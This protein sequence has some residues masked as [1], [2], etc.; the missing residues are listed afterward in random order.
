MEPGVS[1]PAPLSMSP[2]ERFS[3]LGLGL[4]VIL[5]ASIVGQLLAMGG[6]MV[7]VPAKAMDL[8]TSETAL[9]L[10]SFLPMYCLA[11]PAGYLVLR[12]VPRDRAPRG[13]LER[14]A[15]GKYLLLCFPIMV[16]GNML[17]NWLALT[18]SSGAAENPL[19]DF[20]YSTNFLKV[21]FM[22]I[23]APVLEELIFRKCLVDRTA[24]YGEKTA[25]LFSALCFGMFHMNLY[26]FFY[27]FG[28]GVIFAYVYLRTRNLWYTIG[29]HMVINLLGGVVAPWLSARVQEAGPWLL[30]D[31]DALL[32][33]W[34]SGDPAIQQALG[35]VS[36]YGLYL[37]VYLGLTVGGLVLLIL[38]WKRARF[39]S[40]PEELPPK[41]RR[42]IAYGNVGVILFLV[43]SGIMTCVTLS[44][45]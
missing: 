12:T 18:F 3:R 8:F 32:Y 36:A 24:A 27:A 14:G 6:V 21:L 22:V 2:K 45:T 43:L 30:E 40:G 5:L 7:A 37:L 33:F 19:L 39:Q 44:A 28:I 38:N 10:L 1:A 26:Q 17:G 29:M 16:G 31:P 13:K 11:F 34:K 9:W 35:W 25:V 20:A 23:L 4:V 15:F 41:L 42:K